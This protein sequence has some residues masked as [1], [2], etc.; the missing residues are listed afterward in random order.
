MAFPIRIVSSRSL[1]RFLKHGSDLSVGKISRAFSSSSDPEERFQKAVAKV[2]KLRSEPE[3]DSKLK[4]YALYKH[5][6]VG[7]CNTPKPG[8][9]DVVAKY[10]WE[11]WHNLGDMSKEDAMKNYVNIVEELAT[12]I[13]VNE[14]SSDAKSVETSSEGDILTST[15]QGVLTIKLN[16]P[17]KMNAI[18][19]DMYRAIPK[20]L[21]DASKDNSIKMV[22]LTGTGDYYSSGNDLSKLDL[23]GR[24]LPY[25]FLICQND[26]LIIFFEAKSYQLSIF[27]FLPQILP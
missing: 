14:D 24:D 9:F 26:D 6:T 8:M 18:T 20:I 11:A 1:Q 21:E 25:V 4:L 22:I 27:P 7:R 10:K 17:A 23:F 15:K 19:I 2:S 3:N 13:G 5:S 12:T 16:R